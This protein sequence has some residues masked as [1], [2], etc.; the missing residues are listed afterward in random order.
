MAYQ[1]TIELVQSD[2]LPDLVI[3]LRD[4]NKAASGYTLDPS[5]PT[6]W[7][8]IDLT[9]CTVVVKFRKIGTTTVLAT[10]TCTITDATNGRCVMAWTAGVLAEAGSYEAEIEITYPDTRV[11]TVVDLL[12]FK[13]RPEF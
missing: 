6:T 5:D 11:Q 12:K 13:V 2:T 9:G 3:T 8:P 7:A 4:Q 10:M 1:D